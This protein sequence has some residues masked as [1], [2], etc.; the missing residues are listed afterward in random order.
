VGSDILAAVF[1]IGSRGRNADDEEEN[2]EET[3]L[4][5]N[6][7]NRLTQYFYTDENSQ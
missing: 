2:D 5:A 6:T 3:G 7:C 1:D 4:V